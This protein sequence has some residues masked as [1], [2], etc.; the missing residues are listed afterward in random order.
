MHPAIDVRIRTSGYRWRIT[1]RQF[2]ARANQM[3][4][5][6]KLN[7]PFDDPGPTHTSG[8]T[9]SDRA[10]ALPEGPLIECNLQF[11]PG[12]APATRE[13]PPVGAEAGLQVRL[14]RSDVGDPAQARP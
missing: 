13:V 12:D 2:V 8:D 1:G 10:E 5:V 7:A 6:D 9:L 14:E 4:G 3:V 11:E